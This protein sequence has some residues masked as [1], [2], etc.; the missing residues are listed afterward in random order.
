MFILHGVVLPPCCFWVKKNKR[1]RSF[2]TSF[3]LILISRHYSKAKFHFFST[4]A[5][6]HFIKIKKEGIGKA[7]MTDWELVPEMQ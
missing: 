6:V 1:E 4:F 3:A 7:L 2:S 5:K